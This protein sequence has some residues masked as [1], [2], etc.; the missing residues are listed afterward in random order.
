MNAK[1]LLFKVSSCKQCQL[2]EKYFKNNNLPYIPCE[3]FKN[4]QLAK[5][6]NVTDT[7]TTIIV[8]SDNEMLMKFDFFLNIENIKKIKNFIKKE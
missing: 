4:R 7:P 6:Y 2:Q 5:K 1:I 3:L 8:D